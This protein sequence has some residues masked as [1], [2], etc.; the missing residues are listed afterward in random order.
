[1]RLIVKLVTLAVLI[2]V[3]SVPMLSIW[4]LIQERS[5][6]AQ[7]ARAEIGQTWGGAQVLAGPVLSVPATTVR[8]RPDGTE[9]Q[10]ILW[11]DLLPDD[12]DIEATLDAESRRRGLFEAVV[13]TT[14]V[15]LE[16]SFRAT[17]LEELDAISGIDWTRAELRFGLGDLRG[18]TQVPELTWD[19]RPL[20]PESRAAMRSA[21]PAELAVT[22][23]Q[24]WSVLPRGDVRISGRFSLRG[25][26][27]LKVLP[28][29]RQ[30]RAD[31]RSAWTGPSFQGAFLP[32]ERT[33]DASGF[34]ASWEV[35]HFARSY[36]QRWSSE[37]VGMQHMV[38]ASAFGVTLMDTTSVYRQVERS[39]KYAVLFIVLTFG[40][41]FLFELLSGLSVHPVPYLLVGFALALFFLLLLALSEHVGYVV[42]YGVAAS[43]TVALLTAYGV[44]ILRARR[45]ALV[46]GGAVATLYGVLFV[47]VR[48]ETYALLVGSLLLFGLLAL[49][50][51][52][53]RD[54]D[55][56]DAL[57]TQGD[58]LELDDDPFRSE[59]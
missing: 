27:E 12:L 32:S 23:P 30:T 52:L 34:A 2:I 4:A 50:M 15:D 20:E 33:I 16:A 42:A 11:Y 26:G 35:P 38:A 40:V 31:M 10:H 44:A 19:G 58:T 41:V 14:A 46:L 1:M 56:F 59:P 3:L 55:W 13:Y 37:G 49:G 7:D 21:W 54:L 25:S 51:W 24:L 8:T 39:A 57:P 43:A 18:L 28:L 17:D 22:S 53:T 6:R 5:S 47:L 45:R 29:G 36:P 9:E 48:L